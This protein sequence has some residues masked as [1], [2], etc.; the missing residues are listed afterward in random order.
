MARCAEAD[1]MIDELN[2]AFDDRPEPE[3]WRHARRRRRGAQ[4]GRPG[5]NGRG[6]GRI[7]TAVAFLL[8]FL[9]LA[10]LGGGAW[11][12]YDR[13]RG[14]FST[15]DYTSAGT[16]Q[17]RVE[18][19]TGDTITD[20]G[21]T[22][23][24]ADVVK[25]AK[26][27]VNAA[28]KNPRSQNIQPGFYKL[29]SKM[30]AADALALMLDLKNKVVTKVTIPEGRT[31][32]QT[33]ALLS[34]ATGISADTF[35]TAAKDPLKL[36]VP[37]FWFVRG[38][39]KKMTPSIE[40]FLYPATYDFDPDASAEEILRDMVAQ[41]LKVTTDL[42]FVDTVQAERGGISPYDALMVASL[43]QAEAGVPEDLAKITRVAYN[44]VYSGNFP[45][46]CLQFDVTV[47]YYLELMGKPTKASKNFTAAELND[48]KNPYSTHAHPGLPPS[49]IDNPGEQ[50]LRGAMNP[51]PNPKNGLL[52]YFV[53]IDKQGH[54]AFATTIE[55]HERNKAKA[56]QNG[57]L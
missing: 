10:A 8:S 16:G 35:A 56:R 7:R 47:N 51:A 18:V 22:L 28:G 6:G 2:L 5:K 43:A 26:A 14:Y 17:V 25:S 27:F 34:K 55:E 52:L 9:L 36:G 38:D 53:A 15:P 48:P 23:V 20:I 57:V 46:S 12:G 50:A 1:V 21:N 19:K 31:A 42:K 37:D 54:S 41:F 11:Y 13:V 24:R 40:G 44:R 3:R 4:R 32:I 30:R 39:K 49:A 33:F 45:C 29:R